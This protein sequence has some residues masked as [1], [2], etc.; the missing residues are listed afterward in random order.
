[1][2]KTSSPKAINDDIV[3]EIEEGFWLLAFQVFFPF[4]IAGLGMVGAGIVLDIVQHWN[5]FQVVTELF[6][7]VPALLGLKGNLEMTLA[8]R[9]STLAN[10]GLMDSPDQRW[11][12]IKSNLALIQCQAIV[13]GFLASI[14]AVI[15]GWIPE[16]TFDIYHALLISASAVLTASFASFVLGIIMVVVIIISHRYK[17]NPDNVATP[18]A[19]SLGDLTTLGLL[20]AISTWLFNAITNVEAGLWWISPCIL[21]A[22]I[23]LLPWLICVASS[24]SLTREVLSSG[25]SPVLAAMTISSMGGIILDC[26]VKAYN[27]IAVFQPVINGVGGNLVAVQASKLS[28]WLHKRGRPGEFPVNSASDRV[29]SSVCVSPISAFCTGGVHA[30][31]ARVLLLLVLPGH[32]IFT[33]AIYYLQAGHTSLTPVFFVIYMF[34]AFLQVLLLLYI[35]HVMVLWMWSRSIDPDN[36]AIP[37]LTA[38]GDLLGTAFLALAFHILYLIGDKDSDVGD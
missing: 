16:G 23:A 37:Y 19:A 25:W 18:I 15:M 29:V 35:G 36:S 14:A 2:L 17:I 8:S 24:N 20:A 7:L 6:I 33:L 32:V 31:T 38:L 34:S 26:T 9:L 1:M 30:K 5:V 13:V 4:L 11:S 3:E 27:G 10:L 21:C 12:L 22:F 28:T